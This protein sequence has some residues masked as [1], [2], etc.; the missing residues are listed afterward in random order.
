MW[1]S[2]LLCF[3]EDDLWSW[4]KKTPGRIESAH[5][6]GCWYARLCL[7]RKKRNLL[8][9]VCAGRRCLCYSDIHFLAVVPNR[10]FNCWSKICCNSWADM[11]WVHSEPEPAASPVE[12]LYFILPGAFWVSFLIF[13]VWIKTLKAECLVWWC[14]FFN[15]LCPIWVFTVQHHHLVD[16]TQKCTKPKITSWNFDKLN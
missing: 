15:L 4:W 2:C 1:T 5:K 13:A 14:S 11:I 7:Y 8:K 6:S 10:T 3:K 9:T 12:Q 16:N